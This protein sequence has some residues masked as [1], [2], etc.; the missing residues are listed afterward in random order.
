MIRAQAARRALKRQTSQVR[1]TRTV[2]HAQPK[3]MA[4]EMGSPLACDG[5]LVVLPREASAQATFNAQPAATAIADAIQAFKRECDLSSQKRI[6]GSPRAV[7]KRA[8]AMDFPCE[9]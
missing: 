1:N 9:P 2:G 3:C 5:S 7:S 4:I 6:T 8:V